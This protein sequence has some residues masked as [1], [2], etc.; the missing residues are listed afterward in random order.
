MT[1]WGALL[2]LLGVV[3]L[4]LLA[5]RMTIRFKRKRQNS[6]YDERQEIFQGKSYGFGL[7]V[8]GIYFLILSFVLLVMR[9]TQLSGD[10]LSL[11]VMAGIMLTFMAVNIYCMMTE[12]LLPLDGAM[13]SVIGIC[14]GFAVLKLIGIITHICFH[15]MGMGDDPVGA[16]ED[17]TVAVFWS[18]HAAI[19]MIAKRRRK[20]ASDE[21]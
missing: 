18:V 1:I 6:S 11:I 16:W 19:Y 10:V 20:R 8:G 7:A 5:C 2:I 21:Q 9:G 17:V 14:N 13:D 4:L 12:A 15:G 3:A